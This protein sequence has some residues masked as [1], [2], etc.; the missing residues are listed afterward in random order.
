M[1]SDFSS[2]TGLDVAERVRHTG[3]VFSRSGKRCLPRTETIGSDRSSGMRALE[4]IRTLERLGFAV[5]RQTGSHIRLVHEDRPE[6][7]VTVSMHAGHDLS[8]GNLASI[9]RQ[10]GVTREEFEWA[11]KGRK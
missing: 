8:E 1:K 4:V 3:S 6:A 11:R 7:Q 5:R 2:D 9:L 10:A